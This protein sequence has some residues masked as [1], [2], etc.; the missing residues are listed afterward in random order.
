MSSRTAFIAGAVAFVIGA[1]AL[2]GAAFM[3]RGG[4]ELATQT[5]TIGGPFKMVDE[6]GKAVSEQDLKGKPHVVFFGFT[7]CPDVCPT[8]LFDLT[9]A[10]NAMGADAQKAGGV[11]VTVDPERDTP[12]VMKGYLTSFSPLI[13][14]FTGS[15]EQV[16][17]IV[18]AYRVFRKK[19]PLEGGDY[20]M[21]HTA[22]VYLM[23]RN[24]AFVAPLN[25]KRPPEEIAAEI[26]R[27][28]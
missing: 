2:V 16:D 26:R 12:E 25:M 8:A 27:Y 20:T 11:F 24:G 23:D 1:V 13:R 6:D 10:F 22:V 15:P 5:S 9:Q 17:A 18:K 28:G 19:V 7:H 4:G 3:L 14:G 21:D